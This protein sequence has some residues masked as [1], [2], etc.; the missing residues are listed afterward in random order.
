M[1]LRVRINWGSRGNDW[2]VHITYNIF[3]KTYVEIDTRVFALLY[4][5][6][7]KSLSNIELGVR[8]NC[9]IKNWLAY[10]AH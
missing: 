1:K 4:Y 3:H 8:I 6:Y 7:C 10:L 5:E 9:R 2:L